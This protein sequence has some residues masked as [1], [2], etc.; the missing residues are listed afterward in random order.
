VVNSVKVFHFILD[1]DCTMKKKS[2]EFD[3][4]LSS[5]EKKKNTMP[6]LA[7]TTNHIVVIS[8]SWPSSVYLYTMG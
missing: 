4:T 3:L 8:P 5:F 2:H 6:E 1:N 7:T